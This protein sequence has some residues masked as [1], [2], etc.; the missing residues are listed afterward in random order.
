MIHFSF[1]HYTDN[2]H[3]YMR[4]QTKPIFYGIL[5]RRE[6]KRK[7][8][9]KPANIFYSSF[10]G[11]VDNVAHIISIF[12]SWNLRRNFFTSAFLP[13]Y[14]Y[15]LSTH[16]MPSRNLLVN[17]CLIQVIIFVDQLCMLLGYYSLLYHFNI[18]N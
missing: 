17:F 16:V 1:Q 2:F 12:S 4:M 18:H 11:T 5:V 8:T 10:A 13:I 9:D 6:T 3:V 14:Y 7:F 15:S